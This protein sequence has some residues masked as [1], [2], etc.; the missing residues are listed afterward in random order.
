MAKNV[1][2]VTRSELVRCRR[3]EQAANVVRY[4]T[5]KG[6]QLYF[7]RKCNYKFLD[8]GAM[9]GMRIPAEAVGAAVGMFYEG[10]SL[11]AISR[12]LWNMC[13][14]QPSRAT[15]YGWV[16]GYSKKAEELL[17]DMRPI[18]GRTWVVDET[19]VKVGGRNTWFWD[20]IDD[21]TRFLVASHLSATRGANDAEEVMRRAQR[22]TVRAPRF[23]I[24]DKLAAYLE[25]IERV[26]GGDTWHLQSQGF[27]GAINT[28]LIERFHG[29]LKSRTKVMRGLKGPATARTILDGF[30]VHYNYFRPHDTLRG[31][32]PAEAAG[33]QVPYSKWADIVRASKA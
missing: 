6:R 30:L 16:S 2:K 31:K 9:P 1:V 15:I 33:I 28:N 27:Q 22:N 14:V 21:K 8:N 11:A 13:K 32:T 10:M 23:I 7:C 20:A 19:V 24:S 18:T 12:Q 4:G 25:G 5:S 3:C 17:S 29:T 26:F